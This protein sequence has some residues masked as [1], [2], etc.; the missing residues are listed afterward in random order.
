MRRLVTLTYLILLLGALT[1]VLAQTTTGT[2]GGTVSD[3]TGGRV[4]QAAVT[5]LNVETGQKLKAETTGTGDFLIVQVPPGKYEVNVVA[6]G[7]KTL[8]RKGL[9]L[10]VDG[11]ITLDLTL[12]VGS[13]TES[14][15][16]TGEAPLL[17][18]QDAQMGEVVNSLMVENLPQIDRDPLNMLR[19]TGD[20]SG[21]A[22]SA[23]PA[24]SPGSDVRINGGRMQG[25]DVLVDGNSVDSGKFHAIYAG[26]TPTMEQVDEFKVVTNGI[27]AEYGRVS[28]GLVTM[29]TRGGTN[30]IHGRGF[31][32][33]K[34]QLFDANTWEAN[35]ETPYVPGKKAPRTGFHQ[36]DYGGT[37]G[38]PVV[39][40]K[41]YNGKNK[42]FFFFNFEGLKQRQAGN[43]VYAMS[44][45]ANDRVGNLTGLQTFGSSPEMYDPLGDTTVDPKTGYLLK[46]TLFPGNGQIIPAAR[47]NPL[48]TLIDN[49]QP[50]PNNPSAPGNSQQDAWL[51]FQSTATNDNRWEVRMDHNLTDNQRLT[52]RFFRDNYNWGQSDYYSAIS[53][54]NHQ[55]RPGALTGSLGWVWTATP[56]T[57]VEVR[58][59]V[60]HNPNTSH[61]TF[62]GGESSVPLDPLRAQLTQGVP[63]GT[64]FRVWSSDMDGWGDPVGN[65]QS[66]GQDVQSLDSQTTYDFVSSVTKIWGQHTFKTGVD[67]RRMYDNHWEL[68][69]SDAMYQ[70]W[71]TD[72]TDDNRNGCTVFCAPSWAA[73]SWG[74]WL[75]GM[76]NGGGQNSLLNLT[77]EQNYYA[78]YIQDDWKVSKK[79]TLNLGLRWDMESPISDRYNN[80]YAWNP[81][82][83]SAWTIP[84][85]YSWTGSLQA[86]GLTPAQIAQIPTPSWV[87][88]GHLPD[89]AA[90]YV[91]TTA[92]P[93]RTAIKYHP[94]QFA[95]RL[96][97]A[98]ALNNKTVIRASWGM[99]YLTATGD[100]WND[101][102][103]DVASASMPGVPD[104]LNGAINGPMIA[105]DQMNFLP[106]EYVTFTKTNTGLNYNLGSQYEQ[107]GTNINAHP[108]LEQNWNLTVQ[109]ELPWNVLLE[110]GYNGNHS[111][112]LLAAFYNSP[113]PVSALT[114]STALDN[115]FKIQ[116]A[117]PLAGQINN[118]APNVTTG[119]T[120]P[121]GD[122]MLPNPAF[123]GLVVYGNN[124]GRANYNA[125]T[126][127]VQKRLAQGVTFLFTYTYSKSLDDVGTVAG[128]GLG[129]VTAGTKQYQ[130]WQTVNDLYGYSPEDMTHRVTFYHDYQF[131]VGR[132]RKFLGRP[133]GVGGKFLDAVVGGWEY[134]GIWIFHSGTPLIFGNSLPDSAASGDGVPGGNN[135]AGG[136][137]GSI[138]GN[139]AHLT[140]SNYTGNPNSLLTAT[141]NTN[142]GSWGNLGNATVRLF[143]ESLFTAPQPPTPGNVPNIYPYIREPHSNS[144]DASLMKNFS[145]AREGKIY[146]QLRVEAQNVLNIRGLGNYNTGIGG[147]DFGLITNSAQDPR[148]MQVSARLFF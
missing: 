86:A 98:Y 71:A 102:T 135:G 25:M 20:I 10:E 112:D 129:G 39:L 123:G 147:A 76:P 109:R 92:C 23:N 49:Y 6:K 17:R 41:I 100:Y 74:D 139:L 12:E 30:E 64:D 31:E 105:T 60:M 58:G 141:N 97:A 34:N 37:I 56:T 125:G 54:G 148:Q 48:A 73:N 33:F 70:G 101:W 61:Y 57:I 38:G 4:A 36:N 121:I 67:V 51:G 32:F 65:Q 1:A 144:Y 35:N 72:P 78:S 14:V 137:W 140:P 9:T 63:L 94:W 104:R 118:T 43:P 69:Y 59:S 66:G 108:P 96:G 84:A 46:A 122:L 22:T 29:V 3:A 115:L 79:L 19:L 2:F 128:G 130:S 138:T 24:G 113:Y 77:N 127:K 40:P 107:A 85:G 15:S 120:V 88:A 114:G 26:G 90:C 28:G 146:L 8:S 117:N 62:P 16:V 103:E 124:V 42:T 52:M 131:P 143:N 111:S 21:T 5:A 95:P 68:L 11:K 132:G 99:M 44:A 106:N 13:I 18:T 55:I 45:S 80:S 82:A 50:A 93:G 126:V 119:A 133:T 87:T 27:P 91:N 83:P 75:L 47:I 136:L 142:T 110:V 89:G 116:V 134:S 145:I 53:P 7:F 81:N